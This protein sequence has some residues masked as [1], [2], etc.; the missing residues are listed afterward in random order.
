MR[1]T[2]DG[3]WLN[4][5]LQEEYALDE[6]T[7]AAKKAIKLY[8]KVP[9]TNN[10]FSALVP[11]VR[12]IGIKNFRK[13]NMLKTLNSKDRRAVLKAAQYFDYY[14]YVASPHGRIV[15]PFLV[16]QRELEKALFLKPE[17]V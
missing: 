4:D 17:L 1:I 3:K 13:S 6:T 5:V 8:V 2:V 15:D 16:K 7:S 11:L 14:I 10:Q 9:L 12:F